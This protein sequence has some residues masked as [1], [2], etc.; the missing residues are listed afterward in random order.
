[1]TDLH[2]A[3]M[4]IGT[5][6]GGLMAPLADRGRK[7]GAGVAGVRAL[8]RPR[9]ASESGGVARAGRLSMQWQKDSAGTLVMVWT[10]ASPA[11]G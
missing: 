10:C 3:Q 7:F 5:A 8:A 9:T 6:G 2:H 11:A 1:V 4:A